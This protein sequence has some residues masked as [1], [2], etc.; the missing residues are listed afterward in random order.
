M[1]DAVTNALAV[2]LEFG[3]EELKQQIHDHIKGVARSV[4]DSVARDVASRMA[5]QMVEQY[6]MVEAAKLV[7]DT[8]V[9]TVKQ[10]IDALIR[11]ALD[12][13]TNN[14]YYIQRHEEK[15]RAIARQA[16]QQ[17]ELDALAIRTG[18]SFY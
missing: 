2:Q 8:L 16:A 1:T 10:E 14:P 12:A 13:Y 4:A 5:Q 6:I 15:I 7:H 17:L 18:R 11:N 9:V 3:E